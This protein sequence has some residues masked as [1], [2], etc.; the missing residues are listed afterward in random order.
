MTKSRL[1]DS[2][3]ELNI[4]FDD[5]DRIFDKIDDKSG[6]IDFEEFKAFVLQPKSLELWAASMPLA[7]LC[8]NAVSA[9]T[10][11]KNSKHPLDVVCDLDQSSI[12]SIQECM[13]IGF[14]LLLSE[15]VKILQDA[16]ARSKAPTGT[17]ANT[18]YQVFEMSSGDVGDFHGG[19]EGRI[20]IVPASCL[21]STLAHSRHRFEAPFEFC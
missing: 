6:F 2:L 7:A 20:G 12:Q 5:Q 8:A 16:R 15:Q 9:V 11:S 13:S 19:L 17:G 10:Q 3:K 14:G 18:K 1:N 21:G 4:E